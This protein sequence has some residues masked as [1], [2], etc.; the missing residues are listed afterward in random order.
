[1][2]NPITKPHPT[3]L[4]NQ[5]KAGETNKFLNKAWFNT[6]KSEIPDLISVFVFSFEDS[7]D[8]IELCTVCLVNDFKVYSNCDFEKK[9]FSTN[10]KPFVISKTFSNIEKFKSVVN[11]DL[12]K[13]LTSSDISFLRRN[14]EEKFIVDTY[15]F[16]SPRASVTRAFIK[17]SMRNYFTIKDLLLYLNSMDIVLEFDIYVKN[18]DLVPFYN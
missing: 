3:F 1:M 13:D 16:D 10:D 12:S 2:N 6:L 8:Y 11:K 18:N 14:I 7:E 4:K 17:K 5:D 9:T 15:G